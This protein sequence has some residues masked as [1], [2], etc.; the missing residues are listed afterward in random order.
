[1]QIEASKEANTEA[2]LLQCRGGGGLKQGHDS[3]GPARS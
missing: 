3:D 1:M 2:L